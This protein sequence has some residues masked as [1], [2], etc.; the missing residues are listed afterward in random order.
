[1]RQ[2]IKQNADEVVINHSGDLFNEMF[3]SFVYMALRFNLFENSD[4]L[5]Y[6]IFVI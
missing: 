4:K 6:C 2:K 5:T 1:M 3:I